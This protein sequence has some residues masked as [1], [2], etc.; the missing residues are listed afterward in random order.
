MKP[1]KYGHTDGRYSSGQ[2]RGCHRAH[3]LRNAEKIKERMRT[4]SKNNRTKIN[5]RKR[6]YSHTTHGAS[7]LREARKRARQIPANKVLGA[8]RARRIHDR[9]KYGPEVVP[10]TIPDQDFVTIFTHAA[11]LRSELGL[12]HV[13]SYV[14]HPNL[15]GKFVPDNLVVVQIQRTDTREV[16]RKRRTATRRDLRRTG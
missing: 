16:A 14:I 10:R 5:E 6:A 8:I 1:C 2:C 11:N 12:R 9:H 4:H 3:F 13:V 7:V 15:G